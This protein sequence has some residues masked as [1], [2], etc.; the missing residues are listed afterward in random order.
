[1]HRWASRINLEVGFKYSAGK[2]APISPVDG[3]LRRAQQPTSFDH[4]DFH[5]CAFRHADL[6]PQAARDHH[7]ALSLE[8]DERGVHYAF[9]LSESQSD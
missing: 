5:E 8:F 6:L 9:V 4:R 7:L 3:E 1:M 2:I